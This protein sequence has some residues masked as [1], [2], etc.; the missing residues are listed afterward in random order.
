MIGEGL[1]PMVIYDNVLKIAMGHRLQSCYK[2]PLVLVPHSKHHGTCSFSHTE[3][4]VESLPGGMGCPGCNME[5]EGS[6]CGA[7]KAV[8]MW[9]WRHDLHGDMW[10][11]A[12]VIGQHCQMSHPEQ[13]HLSSSVWVPIVPHHKEEIFTGQEKVFETIYIARHLYQECSVSFYCNLRKE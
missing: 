8:T 11:A 2:F 9:L 1:P 6:L 10:A 7:Q 3:Q 12:A 5:K 4:R 13:S